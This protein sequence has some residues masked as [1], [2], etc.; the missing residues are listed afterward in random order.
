VGGGGGSPLALSA[1]AKVPSCTAL[2]M[3]C[4]AA[5]IVAAGPSIPTSAWA[6]LAC[7]SFLPGVRVELEKAGAGAAV[8]RS[9]TPGS[10]AQKPAIIEVSGYRCF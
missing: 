9:C 3:A 10:N 6:P 1:L 5:W 7:S 2:L 8:A 4:W